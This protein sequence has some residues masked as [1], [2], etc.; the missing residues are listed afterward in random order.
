MPRT[1]EAESHWPSKGCYCWDKT[2]RTGGKLI[3]WITEEGSLQFHTGKREGWLPI[4]ICQ[5][6]RRDWTFILFNYRALKKK[7]VIL[8]W[9]KAEKTIKDISTFGLVIYLPALIRSFT[10]KIISRKAAFSSGLWGSGSAGPAGGDRPDVMF[11]WCSGTN[12]TVNMRLFSTDS[13]SSY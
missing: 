11:D 5:L 10:L 13:P 1:S 2:S 9:T 3:F 4:M 8:K 7:K 6:K 12:V